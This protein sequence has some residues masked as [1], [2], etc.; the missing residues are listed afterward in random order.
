MGTLNRSAI[1]ALA[2]GAAALGSGVPV[3]A[4][5]MESR[6]AP[7]ADFFVAPQRYRY[8]GKCQRKFDRPAARAKGKAARKARIARS[9]RARGA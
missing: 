2:L 3:E 4:R 1:L 6:L 7:R 9:Q 5:N 8:G